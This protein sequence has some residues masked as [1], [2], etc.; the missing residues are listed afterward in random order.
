M[1]NLV[2]AAMA[3]ALV[4]SF[5]SFPIAFVAGV[6]IGIGQTELTRYVAHARR[7]QVAAVRRDHRRG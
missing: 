7:R 3:A 6:V 1:T 4:A 2:L 5:R